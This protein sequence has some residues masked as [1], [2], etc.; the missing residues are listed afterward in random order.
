[1]IL[2]FAILVLSVIVQSNLQSV[3]QTVDDVVANAYRE[4]ANGY[5]V[6]EV[7]IDDDRRA[8]FIA[9]VNRL[10]VS[11]SEVDANLTLLK[12]RKAG[13]INIKATRRGIAADPKVQHAAEIASRIIADRTK[14]TTDDILASPELREQLLLES[15]RIVGD[16]KSYDVF[17]H[18]LR[19]RKT[20][21]LKPELLLRVVDWEREITVYAAEALAS[22]LTQVAELPGVYLFRGP[23]GY[24]YIGEASNLRRRLG[25]H[26]SETD[27]GALSRFLISEGYDSLSIEVHQ[28]TKDSPGA[29]LRNR[30]AY[31]SELIRSREPKL[32]VRP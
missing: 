11:I 16:A 4:T 24:L 30:R 9:S 25:E 2:S 23:E 15:R 10:D 20:R 18:M 31:E 1:M 29:T 27:P 13:K 21:Q 7:L 12:L 22:D 32:N 14:A 26:F 28:F 17:K 6:D 8:A 5:S 3:Q 19:L